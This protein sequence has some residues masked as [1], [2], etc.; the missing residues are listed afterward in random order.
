VKTNED[1]ITVEMTSNT[2]RAPG[3]APPGPPRAKGHRGSFVVIALR[4][5][6]LQQIRGR[7]ALQNMAW[8]G[9][10]VKDHISMARPAAAMRTAA[11]LAWLAWEEESVLLPYDGGGDG[12]V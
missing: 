6:L 11:G 3:V 8:H 7:L 9:A 10:S 12:T 4:K 2:K 5:R 1:C